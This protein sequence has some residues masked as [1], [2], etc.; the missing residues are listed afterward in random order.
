M[1]TYVIAEQSRLAFAIGGPLGLRGAFPRWAGSVTVDSRGKAQT[2]EITIATRDLTTGLARRDHHLKTADFFDAERYP[3]IS[4]RSARI[5]AIGPDHY[6]VHGALRLH[7]Q[8]HDVPLDVTLDH[9]SGADGLRWARAQGRFS[10]LA[11]GIPHSHRLVG[12]TRALV[13]DTVTVSADVALEVETQAEGLASEPVSGG[14]A[15]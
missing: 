5:E 12:V 6:I 11:F 1:P 9:G 3:E 8:E 15:A 7:G 10:R 13:S 14:E 2:L 4:Y